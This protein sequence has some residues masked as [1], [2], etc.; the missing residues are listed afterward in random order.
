MLA[1]P[2]GEGPT[3]VACG[4]HVRL[5]DAPFMPI[6]RAHGLDLLDAGD[7][8]TVVQQVL[9]RLVI[10]G[11]PD[12][13]AL[14]CAMHK[15]LVTARSLQ[16]PSP[17]AD[18]LW[19]AASEAMTMC[20]IKRAMQ[21]RWLDAPAAVRS[22][23]R[24][25]AVQRF[26]AQ[27]L[28]AHS[29]MRGLAAASL[30]AAAP[31]AFTVAH[32]HQQ[33]GPWHAC[34]HPVHPGA[35]M[36]AG[37]AGSGGATSSSVPWME[38]TPNICLVY[39]PDTCTLEVD[40]TINSVDALPDHLCRLHGIELASDH[41]SGGG[42][43]VGGGVGGGL[44]CGNEGAHSTLLAQC[45]ARLL[46]GEEAELS[47]AIRTV[48]LKLSVMVRT[49][50]PLTSPAFCGALAA[51]SAHEWH[52]IDID[53]PADIHSLKIMSPRTCNIIAPLESILAASRDYISIC[54]RLKAIAIASLQPPSPSPPPRTRTLKSSSSSFA[55]AA[56]AGA[57]LGYSARLHAPTMPAE[58]AFGG[59]GFPGGGSAR[60]SWRR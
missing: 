45:M 60:A 7:A 49:V 23:S 5:P 29:A 37:V 48:A 25:D 16:H 20:T 8:F 28:K 1:F 47:D 39:V 51:P 31:A 42:S 52:H 19:S 27:V 18:V 24:M 6:D 33:H 10:E 36:A 57:G 35:R 38:W 53:D 55:A 15:L 44:L 22:A 26:Q 59:G 46:L 2:V 43:S 41:Y 30:A 3:L 12:G 56:A 13:E 14:V 32:H 50:R 9:R 58:A 17:V 34:G 4:Q 21:T 40:V 11:A 54:G